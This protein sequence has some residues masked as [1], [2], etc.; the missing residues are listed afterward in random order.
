MELDFTDNG[1]EQ[2]FEIRVK[3]SSLIP[4]ILEKGSASYIAPDFPYDLKRVIWRRFHKGATRLYYRIEEHLDEN[5]DPVVYIPKAIGITTVLSGILPTPEGVMMFTMKHGMETKKVLAQYSHYGSIMHVMIE[6]WVQGKDP[7]VL[8]PHDLPLNQQTQLK[9]NMIGFIKFCED[10]NIKPLACEIMLEWNGIAGTMDLLC[11]VRLPLKRQVTRQQ[12]NEDGTLRFYKKGGTKE[13][14]EYKVNDPYMETVWEEYLS[15][16]MLAIVDFK[17]AL[18]L[19]G[20]GKD[21]KDHYDSHLYQLLFLRRAA[22][23]NFGIPIED[24]LIMNWS[25]LGWRATPRYSV[26]RW[27]EEGGGMHPCGEGLNMEIWE[28]ELTYFLELAKWRG[29]TSA[30]PDSQ[31]VFAPLFD[32]NGKPVKSSEAYKRASIDEIILGN[33]QPVEGDD[34]EGV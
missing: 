7:Y 30:W 16:P 8:I 25:P 29:V 31:L 2:Q 9:K 24:I 4:E 10:Y 17:S 21:S 27:D 11:W 1:L 6:F 28:K 5:G 33:L 23:Y 20:E 32:E 34:V 19:E 22:S 15:E 12:V 3:N 26:T 18:D 13:G 14:V